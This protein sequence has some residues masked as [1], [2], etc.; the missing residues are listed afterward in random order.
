MILAVSLEIESSFERNRDESKVPARADQ[1]SMTI[2]QDLVPTQRAW[3][4]PRARGWRAEEVVLDHDDHDDDD[5]AAIAGARR[6]YPA[7]ALV[8]IRIRC[9]GGRGGVLG[10][11]RFGAADAGAPRRRRYR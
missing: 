5:D 2:E 8:R 9:G 1:S 4:D 10:H 11:H 3:A 7:G 6:G